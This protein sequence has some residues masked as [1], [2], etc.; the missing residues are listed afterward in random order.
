MLAS[1]KKRG[2]SQEL[3][4]LSVSAGVNYYVKIYSYSGVSTSKYLFRAKNYPYSNAKTAYVYGF[5]YKDDAVNTVKIAEQEQMYLNNLGY[6]TYCNTK[7]AASFAVGNSPTTGIS[8]INSG[9]FAFNGHAGPGSVAFID[10]NG[11]YSYLTAKKSG[12][13]YSKMQG[14]NMSDCRAALFFG[15]STASSDRE[16]EYGVL[17]K[18]SVDNGA[19][20]AFGFL[21]SVSTK[22]DTTFRERMFYFLR[23]G[24]SVSDAAYN[25][26]HELPW[27][28]SVRK[29]KI[30]GDGSVKITLSDKK[31]T[32]P[33]DNRNKI[34]RLRIMDALN[35]ILSDD[36]KLAKELD[37]GTQIYVKYIDGIPTL[38]SISVNQDK[39]YALKTG[40]TFSEQDKTQALRLIEAKNITNRETRL[41]TRVT[42]N[43]ITFVKS[44]RGEKLDVF[45]KV[46]G[47]LRLVRIT[48]TEYVAENSECCYLDIVCQDL[49]SGEIID[50]ADVIRGLQ[51]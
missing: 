9:V 30:E 2:N 6:T 44:S 42:D 3:I 15:C 7:V 12:G 40:I 43:G 50:Y 23:F 1:S 24:Y 34:T 25:A 31:G 17:T 45:C 47:Q 36:Y 51:E 18:Q 19:T 27:F 35:L 14:I 22:S 49:N 48:Q 33:Y 26:S 37:D 13:V 16:N 39:G 29:Y 5:D 21:K 20:C 32:Q 28:D 4:T 41:D 46:D 10:A 11:R 8:R 38:E